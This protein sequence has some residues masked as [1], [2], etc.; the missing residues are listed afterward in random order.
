MKLQIDTFSGAVP[1]LDATL[2]PAGAASKAT[3]TVFS[4]GKLRSLN[5]PANLAANG[6]AVDFYDHDG[7]FLTF[8]R[9]TDVVAGPTAGNRLYMTRD[10]LPPV[11]RDMDTATEYPLALPLPPAPAS[12]VI[13]QAA[14]EP[15]PIYQTDDNGDNV[16]DDDGNP[17]ILVAADP[18]PVES[19]IY[20][21]TWV[22]VL[23]EETMPAPPSIALD[24][25]EGSTVRVGFVDQPPVGSRI[26]R[27]RIYR[28]VR[29]SLNETNYF[30][31]KEYPIGVTEYVHD[32]EVDP[33]QE[34]LPSLYFDAPQDDLQG[35][36]AMHNGMMAAFEGKNLYFCEPYMPHAWPQTYQLTTD[37]PIVA[38][39]HF[40]TLLCVLT[41]AEP[42]LCQGSAPENMWLEKVDIAAPCLSARGTVDM[43]YSAAFPTNDGLAVISSGAPQ[44]VTRNLFTR[45]QWQAMNPSSF[46]AGHYDGRYVFTYDNPQTGQPAAGIIDLTGAEPFFVETDITADVYHHASE[47]SRLEYSSGGDLFE[48]DPANGAASATYVWRAGELD[49]NSEQTF[50]VILVR[51]TDHSGDFQAE[52]FADGQSL[53]T[54]GIMN[55]PHRLPPVPAKTWRIEIRGTADVSRVVL[56]GEMGELI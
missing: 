52:V 15:E 31:I 35:I 48:F 25:T 3:N 44:I 50:G 46:R 8:D 4:N 47:T 41:K 26:N 13:E 2:L 29:D 30:F 10:G 42:Y 21:Y 54:I 49:M 18:L 36:T 34:T 56:A 12:V 16:L 33:P 22:S 37:S 11:L 40:G 27:V 20:T 6:D 43:G 38:L 51:G 19:V 28:S 14:P 39:V 9:P 7:V 53:H 45:E 55:A 24:V 23:D 1:K 32:V 5:M 17:I